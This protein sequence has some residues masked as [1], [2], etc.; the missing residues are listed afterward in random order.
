MVFALEYYNKMK[1]KYPHVLDG[2]WKNDFDM[3]MQGVELDDID[4]MHI[5][6]LWKKD[7]MLY[8]FADQ[9]AFEILNQTTPPD[10]T[11]SAAFLRQTAAS[12]GLPR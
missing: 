7:K 11:I 10:Y 2:E 5:L 3:A 1:K 4:I 9:T 6:Q 8:N 12:A